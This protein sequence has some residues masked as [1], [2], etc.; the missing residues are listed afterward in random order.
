MICCMSDDGRITLSGGTNNGK[1]V[2]NKLASV[3]AEIMI[4]MD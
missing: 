3:L 4:D 1:G 2:E